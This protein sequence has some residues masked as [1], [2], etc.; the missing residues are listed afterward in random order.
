MRWPIYDTTVGIRLTPIAKLPCHARA[1][2]VGNIR[3]ME[4]RTN[5]ILQ[6]V[7]AV[8]AVTAASYGLPQPQTARAAASGPAAT[9]HQAKAAAP[10]QR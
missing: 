1:I 9:A 10:Q 4:K 3:D 5:S 8:L 6:R 7:P 2:P